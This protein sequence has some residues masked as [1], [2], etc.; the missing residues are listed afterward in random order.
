MTNTDRELGEISAKL[1]GLK[2]QVSK[3][4]EG[5]EK[6]LDD[7]ESRIRSVEV[8]ATRNGLVAGGIISVGI[9]F[10]RHKLGW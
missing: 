5:I 1:D 4:F 6:K 2:E 3:G 7:H 9:A 10:L 8:K